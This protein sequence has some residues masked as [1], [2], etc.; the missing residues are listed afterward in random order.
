MARWQKYQYGGVEKKEHSHLPGHEELKLV[1]DAFKG[2]GTEDRIRIHFDVGPNYPLGNPVDPKYNA[3]E[4]L[5][6]RNLARGGRVIDEAITLCAAGATDPEYVCQYSLSGASPFGDNAWAGTVGWKTGYRFL[7]DEIFSVTPPLP[8]TLPADKT[9]EDYCN[10]LVPSQQAAFPGQRYACD[11]RFPENRMNAFH[12][13]LMVHSLGLPKSDLPCLSGTTPVAADADDRCNAPKTKNP[14]FHIPRTNGGIGDFPGADT[15][16]ALGAFSDL[17]GRPTGTPFQVAATL[18][19]EFGHHFERRHG[20]GAFEPNCKPTYLSIMNYLYALRGLLDNDGRPHLDY[21]GVVGPPVNETALNANVDSPDYRLGWYAPLATSYL[22]GNSGPAS[23]RCDGSFPLLGED[24]VRIDARFSN[25]DID[26]DAD[27]NPAT[28]ATAQDVNYDGGLPADL[29]SGA[30]DWSNLRLNQIGSR[31]NIGALYAVPGTNLIGVGPLSI[32]M[33]KGDLTKGDLTKGDLTKGDLTKGD[34]TKGDL[35]KG[36]LTKGDLGSGDLGK[37][38][39]GGGDLFRDGDPNTPDG[40]P[41]FEMVGDL[42]RTPPI[43]FDA[44]VSGVDCSPST[45]PL[46]DVQTKWEFP[47]VVGLLSYSVYR[48]PGPELL[49]GQTW[50]HVATV[51]H[52]EGVGVYSAIDPKNGDGTPQHPPLVGGQQYTYFAVGN[53]VGGRSDPGNVVTILAVNDPAAAAND[54]YATNEDTELT[55]PAPGVLVNDGDPDDLQ[56]V[57]TAELVTGLSPATA[58]SLTLNPNGSFTFTPAL[59]FSSTTPVTFTYRARSGSLVTNT[60]T[61]SISVAVVND[62]PTITNIPDQ[63][64]YQNGTVGPIAFTIGDVESPGTLAVSGTS[65]NTTLVP[66]ANIVF[67][68]TGTARTVTITPVTNLMGT[69]TITILV[70]DGTG[71]QATDTFV[72]AVQP[73]PTLVGTQNVPPAVVK[74]SNAG[75]AVPMTWQ[76]NVGSTAVDSSFVHHRVTVTGPMSVVFNDTDPGSSSFRYDPV[77]RRWTFNLQTKT[78]SGQNYPAGTYRVTITPLTSGFVGTSFDLKLK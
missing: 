53:Y 43:G 38:D 3:E 64:T 35:T 62:P 78:A 44:C 4:Y 5:V 6:P 56:L 17:Q 54:A 7:R 20:G 65:S 10:T 37:G 28:V 27:G 39:G 77:S 30:D 11:R 76:Y 22:A 1:G 47:N 29:L 57:F 60:V 18:M 66:N 48:V 42:N 19:H 61:V 41:D 23:R 33:T 24:M 69:T 55:V 73:P 51:A 63:T 59:E 45:A 14:E 8:P 16:I 70:T 75:S 25:V 71:G 12:Y 49:F 31:R 52:V 9:P 32:G 36:D 74:T 21:S 67:G 72:L 26:W 58:G 2:S 34:L 68:G 50:T 15:L 13:A 40:E 46:H